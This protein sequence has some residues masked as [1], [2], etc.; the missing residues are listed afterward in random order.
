VKQ[1]FILF[2]IFLNVSYSYCQSSLTKD[3][4]EQLL[5]TSPAF[6]IFRDNYFIAGTTLDEP[7]SENNSDV[8]FQISFKQR[9]INKPAVFG[10][11]PYL[12]YTQK[13]FWDIFI[14]SSPFAESNYNP[15]LLFIKPVYKHGYFNSACTF[16]I[17]H[18]SNG[19]DS[20]DSRSWNFIA[21]SYGRLF[22]PKISASLKLWVPFTS[23]YENPDLMDYIGYGQA[24][25]YWV[26][27]ENK[28]MADA[29]IRK[30]AE[31]NWKGSFELN[32][33]YRPFK[34][35]NQYLMLQWF[36]GYAESLID[37]QQKHNMLRI[38]FVLKPTFYRFY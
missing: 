26:I 22:S 38:G 5:S 8:K 6:S 34:S 15:S 21:A 13:T 33:A 14:S 2:F 28:L 37:Y 19:L 32:V 3:T 10:F 18:E 35:R 11:Y 7:P 24:S 36:K 1:Y 20:I 23:L 4:V 9:L 12:T 30:G 31:W 25:V 29:A 17:E 16:S 27:K